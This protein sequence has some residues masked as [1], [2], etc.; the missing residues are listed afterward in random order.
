M[1]Y[2]RQIVPADAPELLGEMVGLFAQLS[3]DPA[4]VTVSQVSLALR[5]PGVFILGVFEDRVLV[6]MGTLV[7]API[8]NKTVSFIQDVVI[9]ESQRGKGLAETLM[10]ALLD[11]ACRKGASFCDLTSNPNRVPANRL[12]QRM[13][14]KLRDTNAYRYSFG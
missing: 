10:R 3:Q 6:G 9:A 13:G 5:S 14:F 4:P 1:T 8:L 11:L 12:Y 2:I 7:I